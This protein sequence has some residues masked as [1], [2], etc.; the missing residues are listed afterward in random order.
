MVGG[1][2]TAELVA[3]PPREWPALQLPLKRG[4][5]VEISHHGKTLRRFA[6][7]LK[8]DDLQVGGALY[9]HPDLRLGFGDRLTAAYLHQ[10]GR[11]ERV[12]LAVPRNFRSMSVKL[13]EL[14][15][16]PLIEPAPKREASFLDFL[17]DDEL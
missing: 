2:P 12:S 5:L 1:E 4:R 15:R 3:H 9:L 13:Q 17:K 14:T 11:M 10:N 7:W 6:D 8:L 16:Q